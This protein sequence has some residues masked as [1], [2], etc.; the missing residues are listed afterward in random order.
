MYSAD[1]KDFFPIREIITLSRN[2]S[3]DC[4]RITINKTNTDDLPVETFAV[5]LSQLEKD[6]VVV[7][8]PETALVKIFNNKTG[9]YK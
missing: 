9:M 5:T 1:E 7:L 4:G 6:V 8:E 2:Q 3:R